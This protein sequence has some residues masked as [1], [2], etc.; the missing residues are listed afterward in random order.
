MSF[1]IF[2]RLPKIKKKKDLEYVTAEA[3]KNRLKRFIY[4]LRVEFARAAADAVVM[5]K[6]IMISS[7]ISDI[8][9]Y[10][11]KHKYNILYTFL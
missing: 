6:I 2:F 9:E 3:L 7:V 5:A 4:F 11:K 10:N 8:N 1:L